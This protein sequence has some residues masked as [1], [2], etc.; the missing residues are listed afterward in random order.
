GVPLVEGWL[1]RMHDAGL[2]G[3]AE[4]RELAGVLLRVEPDAAQ[5]AVAA[6]ARAPDYTQQSFPA[7]ALAAFGK[8]A[9]PAMIA[10]LRAEEGD[11]LAREAASYLPVVLAGLAPDSLLHMRT[12][13][14]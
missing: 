4:F 1:R 5:R 10:G 11:N 12:A 2:A 7:T 14:Q 6:H 9:V 3:S 8:P 13:L